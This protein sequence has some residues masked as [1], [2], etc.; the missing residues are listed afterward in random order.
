MDLNLTLSAQTLRLAG[1]LQRGEVVDGV[2]A[3]KNVSAKTYLRVTPAQ[4]A[5]LQEFREP[6]T[7]P[8]VLDHM[9]R[10]RLCPPLGEFFELILKAIRNGI[11]LEPA[12]EPPP[13]AACS[14]RPALRPEPWLY[15]LLV[16]SVGGL[17]LSLSFPLQLPGS[18]VDGAASVLVLTVALSV[19]ALLAASLV[20]GGDAEVYCPRWE[21]LAFTPHLQVDTGDAIMLSR[22]AQIAVFLARASLLA[23]AAGVTAWLQPQWSLVPLLGVLVFMR[24]IASGAFTPVIL[25][26]RERGLS[27]AEHSHL[28]SLNRT[29]WQRW[30]VLKRALRDA[31]TWLR[32]FYGV[33]W[34]L[35]VVYLAGRL[36]EEPPWTLGFW[37]AYGS[38]VAT[39][40]G[41]SLVV[42]AVGYGGWEIYG[43]SR[44]KARRLRSAFRQW[45]A[46]WWGVRKLVLDESARR[47]AI[48][49]SP[50]L[51]LLPPPI[52]L[53][54]ARAMQP[55]RIGP[56]RSLSGTY[57]GQP[58][59]VALIVS[60]RVALCRELPSGRSIIVQ[61]LSDGDV[62]GFHDLADPN[63]PN[64][65]L[66]TLSPTML[67]RLDRGPAEEIILPRIDGAALVDRILKL[68][69][70]RQVSLCENWHFQAILRFATLSSLTEWSKGERI[71]VEGQQAADFCMI[72][73]GTADVSRSSRP[74][75]SIQRG[76]FFGEISLLQNSCVGSTVSAG[77][78]LRCLMIP[79]RE[80]MRFVTHNH[81]VAFELERVSS[82]RLGK[83]IFPLTP[84]QFSPI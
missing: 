41:T 25:F 62:I 56:W 13:V 34:T 5:I 79:R 35:L 47:A 30:R 60:G 37:Q 54:L 22:R 80:F 18:V 8:A 70:L 83:P 52:R 29:P 48:G 84:G 31:T 19:G 78:N 10:E 69:F 73:E 68:P 16:L 12:G 72:F 67:L 59:Q 51:S 24:P 23:V 27:D 26:C 64:Y 11:L 55:I 74:V 28:F 21:W 7:V 6:R 14:W 81:T 71:L 46:R 33:L 40:I 17:A 50:L 57:G 75:G 4:W 65:L 15:P 58:T 32:L 43:F 66:R 45:H 63:R 49:K 3:I 82:E 20:R 38:H 1:E 9:I 42:L 77:D 53:Q 36:T 39:G 44:L 2:L 61:V 76:E